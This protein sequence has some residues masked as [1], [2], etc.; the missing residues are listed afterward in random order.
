[1]L[2]KKWPSRFVGTCISLV[3]F[4]DYWSVCSGARDSHTILFFCTETNGV[5]AEEPE[6][7][8]GSFDDAV[9]RT[10]S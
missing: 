3:C 2:V 7:K 6:G 1:M 8:Y 5:P 10:Y 4:R 9:C